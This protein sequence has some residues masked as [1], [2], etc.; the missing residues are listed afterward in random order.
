MEFWHWYFIVKFCRTKLVHDNLLLSVSKTRKRIHWEVTGC[1]TRN[2]VKLAQVKRK[3]YKGIAKTKQNKTKTRSTTVLYR[4]WET[5]NFFFPSSVQVSYTLCWV[6]SLL[7]VPH[8]VAIS[9]SL[10]SLVR[11]LMFTEIMCWILCQIPMNIISLNYKNYPTGQVYLQTTSEG[12]GRQTH[13]TPQLVCSSAR[14]DYLPTGNLL[15]Q[16]SLKG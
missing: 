4:K 6:T 5:C 16:P 15:A 3:E 7:S 1:R 12:V 14:L 10:E 11:I 13:Q 8:L 9:L 2:L